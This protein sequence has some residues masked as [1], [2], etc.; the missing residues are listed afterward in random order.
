MKDEP[1]AGQT[2]DVR[3][4]SKTKCIPRSI[5]SALIASARDELHEALWPYNVGTATGGGLSVLAFGV[6]EA[7]EA[8][9][10]FALI[11]LDI[12]NAHNEMSRSKSCARIAAQ[13]KLRRLARAYWAQY[14]PKSPIFFR[15]R[16]G[17]VHRALFNSEEGMRQGCPLVQA[18][19]SV[20]LD[21][22]VRWLDSQLLPHGGF[23][24]FIHDD[25]YAFGPRGHVFRAMLYLQARIREQ[26]G[27]ELQIRK[28]S[29]YSAAGGL[30]DS[31]FRPPEFP[32][33]VLIRGPQG[34]LRFDRH[35]T[36]GAGEQ[37][38]YE[39]VLVGGVPIGDSLYVRAYLRQIASAA[40]SRMNTVS[41]V[42][43][44]S[45][46]MTL[47]QLTVKCFQ[48]VLILGAAL[49]SL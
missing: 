27:L 41:A 26:L 5:S 35:S 6:R 20:C 3:P 34:Q 40:H 16:N 37:T 49:L 38:A 17:N 36:L 42:L 24:R 13:P 21:P 33:S 44:D 18:G 43:R 45:C 28:C 25:G 4:V 11:K 22:D 31:P 46:K 12:W 39:G 2:P 1:A 29:C 10:D 32:V 23:A 48:P 47:H 9:P 19:F 14:C 7:T 15:E 30:A 8:C